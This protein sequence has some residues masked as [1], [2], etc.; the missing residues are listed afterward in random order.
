MTA[1]AVWGPTSSRTRHRRRVRIFRR[2]ARSS[3]RQH[4]SERSRGSAAPLILRQA[5]THDAGI[6]RRDDGPVRSARGRSGTGYI[7]IA[8]GC[9]RVNR[10]RLPVPTRTTCQNTDRTQTSV[11]SS[12]DG[13]AY[14]GDAEEVVHILS[15]PATSTLRTIMASRPLARMRRWRRSHR[16]RATAAEHKAN[17]EAPVSSRRHTA[18]MYAARGGH[19][20]RFV[21]AQRKG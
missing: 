15:M 9:G 1:E 10:L 12:L 6:A 18:L 4:L 14:D 8:N 16:G 2:A 17:L 3:P 11:R 5:R 20:R 21:L 7:W 13:S 19:P